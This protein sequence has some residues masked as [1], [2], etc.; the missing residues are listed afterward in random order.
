[1]YASSKAVLTL[2]LPMI[3]MAY[4]FHEWTIQH[5]SF[6]ARS[7]TLVD[8]MAEGLFT[9]LGFLML[10]KVATYYMPKKNIATWFA[11]VTNLMSLAYVSGGRILTKIIS[12]L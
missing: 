5:F 8:N 4:G 7:I 6:G 9:K 3:A 11:L 10:C 2:Q 1:M 12:N